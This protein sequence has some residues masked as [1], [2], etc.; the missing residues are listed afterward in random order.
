MFKDTSRKAI[1]LATVA[2]ICSM[3]GLARADDGGAEDYTIPAAFI[4]GDGSGNDPASCGDVRE[5]AAF[6]HELGRTDGD[7]GARGEEPYCK[8]DLYAESTVDAD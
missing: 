6:E 8:P 1:A 4:T 2:A 5:A 3:A 7:V